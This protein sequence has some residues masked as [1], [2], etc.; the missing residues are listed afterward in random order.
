MSQKRR[1]LKLSF[2]SDWHI[3][4]GAGIPGSVDRQVLRDGDGLPYVPGKTLTG[5]LRDAAEWVADTRD[6]L[7]N[8]DRW[9]RALLSLF[10][11][12]PENYYNRNIPTPQEA[13][14]AKIGI[15]SARLSA[16]V[17]RC[18]IDAD[19]AGRDSGLVISSALVKVHPGVKI[20]PKT[21]RSEEKHLFSTERARWDCALYADVTLL[22]DELDDDEKKLLDDA[23][24]AAR[25]IGGKRRRGAG[26]CRMAWVDDGFELEQPKPD[27]ADK[28]KFDLTRFAQTDQ[29]KDHVALD[30]RLTTLQPLIVNR[31]NIGNAI[32][33]DTEI[34]GTA[35]LSYYAQEVLNPLGEDRLRRAIME[36][37][38][39]AGTFLPE[40]KVKKDGKQ[41]E[42]P[43]QALPVPLCLAE[44]KEEKG[45][46]KPIINGLR[47][48]SDQGVQTKDLRSGYVVP[49]EKGMTY[50][51][52]SDHKIIRTHNTIEDD[53]Q[54]PTER[55][56]GL[57]TYEAIQTGKTFRGT[58]KIGGELW[59]EIRGRED[60]LKKL[61]SDE[62]TFGRSRKDEYGR[63][64]LECA[65]LAGD[66]G[67]LSQT[68]LLDG[69]TEKGKDKKYLVVYLASDLLLRDEAMGYSVKVK[70]VKEALEKA[71]EVKLDDVPEEEWEKRDNIS[72]SPLG[73]P[74]GHSVRTGRRESWQ[75]SW[76]LPRPAMVYFK[77]GSVF[78]F[79]VE[80]PGQ[81]DESK[82][83][84]LV[85]DGLGERRAEGY[86]RVLLNPPFLCGDGKVER[87]DKSEEQGKKDEKK[88]K[89]TEEELKF[90]KA[91]AMDAVKRRFKQIARQEAYKIAEGEI[92]KP[93]PF[94]GHEV[95][96]STH[97]S[98]S[99]FGALREAAATIEPGEKGRDIFKKW[100]EEVKKHTDK[101][102]RWKEK[103]CEMFTSLGEK[104]Q[105]IWKLRPTF[106]ELKAA[107]LKQGVLDDGALNDMSPDL[108]GGFL[109]ILCEAV[110]DKEKQDNA[111]GGEVA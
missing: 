15:G 76:N 89:L 38:L 29:T 111:K 92:E 69:R 28:E 63:A 78:L 97:P 52:A 87:P 70:D 42:E 94:D 16:D 2:E 46:E 22:K 60:I 24:K 62:H 37:E 12:Q 100:V 74:R 13:R 72:I 49:N 107:A 79:K 55:V 57:F 43:V 11:E 8:G 77:A 83:K 4:T 44:A 18:I 39:F 23:V 84:A 48:A 14:S 81:W 21:G 10:G 66:D 30:I 34:P 64:L 95:L 85:R 106:G 58:L 20:D 32:E 67:A 98:A 33:T 102:G 75:R 108:L 7:A 51:V 109:D 59:S 1:R 73:G 53:V 36:G 56:G 91:L 47:E 90:V 61:A 68:G 86:G 96:W 54:R 31:K 27:K 25:R 71:L 45:G 35:L 105:N 93:A 41:E 9:Q 6:Q 3:G 65:G 17:R 104:P 101:E 80:D 82:A 5:I 88:T 99:Q 110:F 26:V 40:F 50:H 103:W 19:K